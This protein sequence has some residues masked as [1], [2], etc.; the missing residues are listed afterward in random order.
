MGVR[1]S[2]IEKVSYYP[3]R[4]WLIILSRH[5]YAHGHN[6]LSATLII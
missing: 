6:P 1:A 3:Y 5:A 2:R 4:G